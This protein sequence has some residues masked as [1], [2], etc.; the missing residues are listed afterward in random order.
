[1]DITLIL[2]AAAILAIAGLTVWAVKLWLEVFRNRASIRKSNEQ[3]RQFLCSSLTILA[4]SLVHEQVNPTEGCIRIK[5]ILDMVDP[6]LGK[7]EEYQIFTTVYDATTHMPIGEARKT[8]KLSARNRLD[9]ERERL[10]QQHQERIKQAAQSL[11]T[12]FNAESIF[13]EA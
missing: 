11:L 1:M 2:L 6:A 7:T 12:Q 13:K 3:H 9:E 5:T 10:E 8:M 4:R